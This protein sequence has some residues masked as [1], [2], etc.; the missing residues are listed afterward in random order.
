MRSVLCTIVT[1]QNLCELDFQDAARPSQN[2]VSGHCINV[3]SEHY[4]NEGEGF[5]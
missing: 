1:G 5:W 3:L 4:H 2:T